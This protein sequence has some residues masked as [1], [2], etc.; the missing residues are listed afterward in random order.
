MVQDIVY[1]RICYIVYKMTVI[2]TLIYGI[3]YSVHSFRR[4]CMLQLEHVSK[5]YGSIRAV[6]D[7]NFA[8]K[9]RQVV[10]LLGMNGAGKS[11]TLN[12]ITGCTAPSSGNILINGHNIIDD[13]RDAKREFGYLPE[14]VPLYDEM[15]VEEYLRFVCELKE[16]VS[17]YISK[18]ICD[19]CETVG[20]RDIMKRPVINL[21]K[22]L[23][24]RVG[25]AQALCGNPPVI[26]LD[27][28]TIGLDPVQTISFR[29]MIRTLSQEHT[30]II[31]SHI[32]SENT[33]SMRQVYNTASWQKCV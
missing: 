2:F 32:L 23:R 30:I 29:R 17:K 26:I 5:N 4:I 10:G 20:I 28:P 18:H 22:G 12:M 16:I 3:I 8:I 1:M 14:I 27:E 21:S 19:I 33:G 11:T 13:H 31:S 24:Q 25:I 9:D 7:L 15:T 6:D